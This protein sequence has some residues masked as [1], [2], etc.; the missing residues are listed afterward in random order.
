[1]KVNKHNTDRSHLLCDLA[2]RAA[3]YHFGQGEQG[4]DV[5]N[6]HEVV[7]HIRQLPHQI[8]A[9]HGA[10]QD[11][12]QGDE[13]VDH[14]AGLGVLL[15]EKPDGVDLAEQVPAQNRG[16]SEEEQADGHEL[17]AQAGTHHGAEGGLGQVGLAEGGSHIAHIAARQ[18]AV[19]SVEGADDD[20]RIEGQDHE[21][22]D[23]HADHGH[24]ALVVGVLHVGLSVGMGGRAHT[25]LVGEQ[26]PLGALGNGLL[27]GIAEGAAHDGL[28]LKGIL[29][30][31]ADG[32]GEILDAEDEDDEAAQQE[33]CRHNGDDFF[34]NGGQPLNAAQEND[35]ADDDQ[36]H[37]HD[38]GG[39]AKSGLEALADGVG[40]HHA[41]HEAQSQD[42]GHGEEGGQELAEA[43]LESGGD[44]VDGAA[45]DGAVSGLHPGLDG[46]RG[47]SIDGGHAEEGNDPHPEDGAGAAGQ[48]STGCAYD[49]AG[50]H[51]SGNGGG[52][53][54][55][56]AHAAVML[57]AVEGQI[58]ED[59]AHTLAEAADLNEA[60]LDAVP[61][62]DSHQQK[63][64]NVVGQV[65]VDAAYSGIKRSVQFC[66]DRFHSFFLLHTVSPTAGSLPR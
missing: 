19:S 46:Q 55:K 35:A 27:D 12:H 23:E 3:D 32:G 41:A 47:F 21:G 56:G 4:D 53:C 2:F 22:V 6:D 10:H 54:L 39:D 13:G 48:N 11:E 36:R 63:D 29:E 57:F 28:G 14:G 9:H 49:V 60:G 50:A 61:Q 62:A 17:G 43:A 65:R 31:H 16:E 52:Q 64:Q 45:V 33:D 20:Q 26:A 15:A 42:D 59:S 1:M 38:P 5:G 37:T 58:A 34:R 7:E 40:L 25:G 24:H 51:L 8:V 44:V 18:R 30:D 66:D